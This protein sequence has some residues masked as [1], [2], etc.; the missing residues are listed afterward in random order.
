MS[1]IFITVI[2]G[3]LVF[4]L[5][6][7]VNEYYIKPIH[8]YKELRAKISYSLILYAN[9]YAN[10]VLFNSNNLNKNAESDHASMELR[11]LAAEIAAMIELKP[12]LCPFIANKDTLFEV[13]RNLIGLSNGFYCTDSN[14]ARDNEK[15]RNEICDLIGIR[16]Y[17]QDNSPL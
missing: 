2:S 12:M 17:E 11:R 3:V 5:G 15:R 10:P 4:V 1:G 14:M 7:I 16:R 8:N 6:Q 9:L 13:S